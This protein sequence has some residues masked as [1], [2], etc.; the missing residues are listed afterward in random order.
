MPEAGTGRPN[1]NFL[2]H[3][4]CDDSNLAQLT[5]TSAVRHLKVLDG[6]SGVPRIV[7]GRFGF[8]MTSPVILPM[9]RQ[10][11]VKGCRPRDRSQHA[12]GG[13]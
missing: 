3:I 6:A 11:V 2:S 12:R 7:H 9:D 10:L 4:W 13:K 1:L 5:N 8:H